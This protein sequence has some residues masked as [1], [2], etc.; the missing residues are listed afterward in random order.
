M[1]GYALLISTL[2]GLSTML[3]ALV[4]LIKIKEENINRFIT[5]SLSFSLAIM[6]GISITDLIPESF[7]TLLFKYGINNSIITL[8]ITIISGVGVIGILNLLE[9]NNNN[10]NNLYKLGI[11][12]MLALMIHNFPEGVATFL[13]SINDINLGIK[14]SIAIMLHNIPEGI[15]IA[16]PIYYGTKSKKRS[17]KAT[18]ISGLSEPLGALVA[19]LILGNFV[20]K[21]IISI[22]L[23]FVAGIMI[24]ISIN[25]L[26]PTAL[27]YRCN[28][29]LRIGLLV[30]LLFLIISLLFK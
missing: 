7:Y 24:S 28:K 21:E 18:L 30:G 3:G 1:I 11:I 26:L 13:S 23:L 2:A 14:L 10:N 16:V 15:S 8:I 9:K 4:I 25:K 22:V 5:F 27:S 20:T 6:I 17:V 12:N 29:E 19:Y